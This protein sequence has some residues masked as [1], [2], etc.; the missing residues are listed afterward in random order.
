M[1]G[2]SSK[3]AAERLHPLRFLYL[4]LR[5]NSCCSTMDTS[6][7]SLAEPS[8]IYRNFCGPTEPAALLQVV[9]GE[10]VFPKRG[11]FHPFMQNHS[12]TKAR[13]GVRPPRNKP[14]SFDHWSLLGAFL[15]SSQVWVNLPR[16]G[17]TGLESRKASTGQVLLFSMTLAVGLHRRCTWWL[18]QAGGTAVLRNALSTLAAT[19][20]QRKLW[21]SFPAS[22]DAPVCA[23]SPRERTCS[24]PE[25]ENLLWT[26]KH[27]QYKHIKDIHTK[28]T[29]G[30]GSRNHSTLHR[31][32]DSTHTHL[33]LNLC[34][35]PSAGTHIQKGLKPQLPRD[36]VIFRPGA[37][38]VQDSRG[39]QPTEEGW[40]VG[41]FLLL[42]PQRR[43]GATSSLRSSE[44]LQ[45]SRPGPRPTPQPAVPSASPDTYCAFSP[46]DLVGRGLGHLYP[47]SYLKMDPSPSVKFPTTLVFDRKQLRLE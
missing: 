13:R 17:Y 18:G 36:N 41:P 28:Y 11:C 39:G 16:N 23:G 26:Y 3:N 15:V 2:Q 45:V 44:L 20:S 47:T 31:P 4:A 46:Q 25:W 37:Q 34:V 33:S 6:V 30:R 12:D 5:C 1:K 22:W 43:A 10:K 7:S 40:A 19:K 38:Q 21:F 14:F 27:S 32:R 35:F 29:F 42:G 9:E 24:S 8:S